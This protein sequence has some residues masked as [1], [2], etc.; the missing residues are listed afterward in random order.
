MLLV[1]VVLLV[2][3]RCSILGEDVVVLVRGEDLQGA[4][5]TDRGLSKDDSAGDRGGVERTEG[6]TEDFTGVKGAC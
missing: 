5:L 6:G 1:G 3:V 2:G 4:D